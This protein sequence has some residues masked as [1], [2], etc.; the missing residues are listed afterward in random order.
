MRRSRRRC[1]GT[2]IAIFSIILTTSVAVP[3]AQAASSGTVFTWGDDALGQLGDGGT[4]TRLTPA[5]IGLTDVVGVSGGRDHALALLANGTVRAWGHNNFGQVGDGTVTNRRVP[6]AVSGLTNVVE[7]AA[8][9]YHSLALKADGTVWAWGQNASGQLGDGTMTVRRTPVQVSGLS[10]VAHIAGGR[11]MSYAVKADGTVW[12]W[13]L[14]SDGELGD[15]TITTRTMP[16]RVGSLTGV[17]EVAAGRDHGLALR[18]DGSVWAWGDNAYGEL[19]QGS[20]ADRT[21][22]GQVSGLTGVVSLTA[23][24]FHSLALRSDGTVRAW[25]RNNLGQLGDGTIT[26]RSLPVQVPGLTGVAAVGSGRD[27]SLAVM[28]DGTAK[29]WGRNDFGQLGDGSTSTRTAPVV[30]GGLSGVI[31]LSGGQGYTV[32]LAAPGPPDMTPPTQPGKPSGSSNAP[33]SIALSWAASDDD[34]SAE[35]TYH[36][37]RDGTQVGS[38]TSASTTT[39]GFTDTGLAPSSTHTYVVVAFDAANNVSTPSDPSDPI[40]VVAGPPM[41][42]SDDFS[43]G[44]LSKWSTVTRLVIDTA[45]GDPAPSAKAQGPMSAFAFA[46]LPSPLT[47]VCESAH[48]NVSARGTNPVALLRLLTSSNAGIVRMFV[49]PSGVLVAKADAPGTT[50]TSGVAL[51]SGWVTL[52]LCGTVSG[53]AGCSTSTGMVCASCLPGQPVLRTLRSPRSRSAITPPRP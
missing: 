14:N 23:G 19:G 5:S 11:D 8:G 50:K 53:T 2:L 45:V 15:G 51:G 18:S 49:N 37:L 48:V 34:V 31:D 1:V 43:S 36:V 3:Q 42:F 28:Q 30:V 20:G 26:N 29:A 47:T 41:I 17:T 6:T 13:G 4:A 52:E 21:N 24:A 46:T 40:I 12:A 38:I 32:A 9:H 10:G 22:P 16:V 39:V 27:H 25:G 44:N 35:I 33:G 7:V